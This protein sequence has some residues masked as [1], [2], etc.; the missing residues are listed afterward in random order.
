MRIATWNLLHATPIIGAGTEPDLSEQAKLIGADIIAVQ[1]VDRSQPRSSHQHQLQEIANGLDLPH[2]VYAPTLVGT[3][4]ES[5]HPADDSHLHHHHSSDESDVSAHYGNGLASRFPMRDIEVLRFKAAPISLPLA[6]PGESGWQMLKV[7][8]EPRVAIIATV[9]T[10]LGDV[11]VASTHL[12][13]VPGFNVKQL[14]AVTKAMLKRKQ[15]ALLLGDFNL[16]GKIPERVTRWQSLAK[17]PTYPIVKPRIQF[18][19]LLGQGF[20][21]AQVKSAQAHA[22][23]LAL[24]VSDHCA[25]VTEI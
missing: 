19:H 9:A 3:P 20:E 18:D 11:T 24:A 22:Q 13:F 6:V 10:P 8:D 17:L 16:I 15:P 12:S 1:E 23:R 5:W 25:L 4:G 7:A 21:P 2:W 14:R